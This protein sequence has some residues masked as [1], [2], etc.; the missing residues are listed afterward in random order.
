MPVLLHKQHQSDREIRRPAKLWEVSAQCT[1]VDRHRTGQLVHLLFSSQIRMVIGARNARTVKYAAHNRKYNC[2]KNNASE[3]CCLKLTAYRED[4][5][6]IFQ[7]FHSQLQSCK[8]V[9]LTG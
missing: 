5:I 3:A 1:A 4:L 6:D 9:I 2:Y 8:T 7:G